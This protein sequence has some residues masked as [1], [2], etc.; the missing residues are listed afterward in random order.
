MLT[1]LLLAF[2]AQAEPLPPQAPEPRKGSQLET[3]DISSAEEGDAMVYRISEMRLLTP[4]MEVRAD[5]ITLWFDLEGY[6]QHLGL[7]ELEKPT[8][9][10]NSAELPNS[11]KASLYSGLWSRKVLLAL[12]LPEDASLIREIRLEGHVEIRTTEVHLFCD[13]MQDWPVEGRSLASV[14]E[15]NLPPG[16]GGP[17]GWP[18]RMTADQVVETPDGFIVAHGA[19]LSTCLERPPHYSVRFEELVAEPQSAGRFLWHPSGGWLQ[20]GGF[21][22]L[23]IPTPDFSQESNFLGFRGIV[24]GSSRRLGNAIAPR[25]GGRTES[26][27]GRSSLDWTFEPTYS[28]D[29]GFPLEL[30]IKGAAPG[31]DTTLD[32]FYL[33][34][35]G[36]DQ[37]GLIRS[38]GRDSDLR[39]RLRWANRWVLD[40]Q[41]WLDFDVALASDPL[42]D[43]EFFQRSWTEENDAESDLYLRRRGEDSFFSAHT[44]Y[45]LDDIG[46]TPIEGFGDPPDAAPQSLDTLPLLSFDNFSSTLFELPTSPFGGGENGSPFN[47]SWGAEV[48]RLQLRDRNLI[49]SGNRTF[50]SLPTIGRTR[51]RFWGEAAVPFNQSGLFF[52]PGIRVEGSIWEDDY[53]GAEQD[54]QL[55]TEVFFETGMVIEKRMDAGWRHLVL[56]QL[57]FRSRTANRTAEGPLID[58]DGHDLLEDGEV[59]EFSLRQF[60]YAP[61]GDG[62]WLDVNLLMPWY[63]DAADLLDTSMTPFPRGPQ[64]AGVGPAELRLTWTPGVYNKTL[65]NVRWDARVRHDFERE[66]T[67][68]VFTRITVRPDSS[69]YYGADYYEASETGLDFALGSLFGGVRF[70][71]EWALG[72]RQS[73]SFSGN[74]GLRSAYAAQYYGHDFLFEFGYQLVQSTGEEG[75]YF[76]ISP[77]FFADS[78]GSRDLA[79]L[80]FQ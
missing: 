58:F 7:S 6:R 11:N 37:H 76:N 65:Q 42:V 51:G 46:F 54:E 39:T 63:T 23:P 59:L 13:R 30:R 79:K 26:D 36:L 77:R 16:K 12:G 73:K 41:W 43:P 2:V 64:N 34:D 53:L 33:K 9:G 10:M 28:S 62:P 20:L 71:E 49:A 74:A 32:L 24:F 61:K 70:S 44:V 38:L 40:D 22:L 75:I 45:R 55:F 3:R 47:L 19:T 18:V 1:T 56:P 67:E 48:G 68:E 69:L 25:F 15:M 21:S 14:V 31:Y 27:D 57:R 78:Y 66:T 4:E 17:N 8:S 60:F 72:F 50:G 35:L 5:R 52:R 29:R 80:N